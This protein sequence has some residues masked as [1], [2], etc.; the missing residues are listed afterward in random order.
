MKQSPSSYQVSE[1]PLDDEGHRR[2][3]RSWDLEADRHAVGRP[4]RKADVLLLEVKRVAFHH[5]LESPE[6]VPVSCT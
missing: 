5:L 3:D 2:P 1:L 4:Q 6:S